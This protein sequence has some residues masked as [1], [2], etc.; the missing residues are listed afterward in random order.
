MMVERIPAIT[1]IASHE[2]PFAALYVSPQI[3][4]EL[5]ITPQE[6]IGEAY[7]W[8]SHI[9]PEDHDA[10]IEHLSRCINE[11]RPF[12]R[13][14]R[15]LNG[16]GEV[17]W[18]RDDN[19][20]IKDSAGN[21]I[22]IE[23]ILLNISEL[24]KT[25]DELRDSDEKF[26]QITTSINEA[27]FL[28]TPEQ[29]KMIYMSPRY[30]EIWGYKISDLYE[31]PSSWFE[32]IHPE[33]RDLISK[34][35]EG[36]TG[37][38]RES[39]FRIIRPDGEIRWI[40]SRTYPVP[41]INGNIVRIAGSA[42]D[43][44]ENKLAQDKIRKLNRLYDLISQISHL[45]VRK[46]DQKALF[47]EVCRIAVE[48]GGF[49]MTWVGIVDSESN[50]II[51]EASAGES[52]SYLQNLK[53][54]IYDP[55]WEDRPAAQVI[56]LDRKFIINNIKKDIRV[57]TWADEALAEGY[58][59]AA[60]FPL[61]VEGKLFGTITLFSGNKHFFDN[62]EVTLLE[63]LVKDISFSIEVGVL[64]K[65]QSEMAL[66]ISKSEEN[67]R[68]LYLNMNDGIVI[69]QAIPDESGDPVDFLF[70]ESNPAFEKQTGLSSEI[71]RGKPL[72]ISI[73]S[74]S[75]FI[76]E[77]LKEAFLTGN[78]VTFEFYYI[79]TNNYYEIH[80]F[81]GVSGQVAALFTNI[82]P[83]K[84]QQQ[85]QN[86]IMKVDSVITR[87]VDDH[88]S[89][90]NQILSA[91]DEITGF[92]TILVCT[93]GKELLT[94]AD[95]AYQR[96]P[97]LPECG[98][99]ISA[100]CEKFYSNQIFNNTDCG[101]YFSG[102]SCKSEKTTGSDSTC[103]KK[104]FWSN[105]I[106]EMFIEN[107][108][109]PAGSVSLF[110]YE[111]GYESVISV[112]IP[113]DEKIQYY[114]VLMGKSK[115]SISAEMIS[116]MEMISQNIGI[117]IQKF[118]AEYDRNQLLAD[119]EN[120]IEKRTKELHSATIIAEAASQTKSTF[121]ANVS[122][123]LRT[124]LNSII[125]FSQILNEQYYG[126]LNENQKTYIN[127]ILE[128][129][130]HL[131]SLINDLLDLSKI[132]ADKMTLDLSG[133]NMGI[134]LRNSLVMIKEKCLKH[135][136]ELE[137]HVSDEL[138]KIEITADER[139]IKQIIFNLLSNA[140]KF[141]PDNGNIRVEGGLYGDQVIVTVQDSGIGI[142]VDQLESIFD[143][144]YQI[145][146][147]KVSAEPGTGLGL[148][149]SRKMAE[150][151]NGSLTAASDGPDQGSRFILTIPYRGLLNE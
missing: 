124:P 47:S 113:A 8:A 31:N 92:E 86:L 3:E 49:K 39:E 28:V 80:V 5:G 21:P 65:K 22:Y 141:T 53:I 12:S 16:K 66:L 51:V 107:K 110:C 33:D 26:R 131:L 55:D 112:Q 73:E 15:M 89:F 125:G 116:T 34:E 147:K 151:H 71:Y 146:R 44:T 150:L 144:F 72:R 76:I 30:E 130:R 62:E 140:S 138:E 136:I 85:M 69:F 54:D 75:E 83:K 74:G 81:R 143:V 134:L 145:T 2:K 122:H 102:L 90:L 77:K 4:K 19:V 36:Y 48:T 133:F 43:I 56:Q 126:P 98:Y 128:S 50:S 123:E 108:N 20:I 142:P 106:S 99:C 11:D 6:W 78:A 29:D 103:S 9:H 139:K 120:Q 118:K 135:H 64:E 70:L 111:S 24:K 84:N 32:A 82:T 67:Y 129:G 121:I 23:G 60:A 105:S 91:V 95:D 97:F 38:F 52:V 87:S 35:L 37:E 115:N 18:L 14:Y 68:S 137:L 127:D 104:I 88:S 42:R 1:Y 114:L 117:S 58:Q 94:D 79:V 17:I 148:T 45:M 149:L 10:V 59:S 96:Y 100:D 40:S 132:E 119:L 57:H 46:M 7:S 109:K 63:N 93:T 25:E 61:L 41:D 101:N 13:E 27:F